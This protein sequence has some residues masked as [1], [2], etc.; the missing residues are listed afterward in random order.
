VVAGHELLFGS[1]LPLCTFSFLIKKLSKAVLSS[2]GRF[3][4]NWSSDPLP[5]QGMDAE[6]D[7]MA[8][9]ELLW[10]L[11]DGTL[12]CEPEEADCLVMSPVGPFFTPLNAFWLATETLGK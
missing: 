3:E 1:L 8:L 6:A 7:A 4:G 11:E 2:L 9:E 5:S 12:F 10:V